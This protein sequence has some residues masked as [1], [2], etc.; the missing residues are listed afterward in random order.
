L[1]DRDPV[2][3]KKG[4]KESFTKCWPVEYNLQSECY[5]YK[6]HSEELVNQYKSNDSIHFFSQDEK[7]KTLEYEIARVNY[8]NGTIL[9]DS[10]S[11]KDELSLMMQTKTFSEAKNKCKSDNLN[12]IYSENINWEDNDKLVGLISARYLKSLQK[13]ENALELANL[14]QELSNDEKIKIVV[15]DYI[16]TAI[17]WLLN[18]K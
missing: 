12:K 5:D 13:G 1:T 14:L 18:I 4:T 10:I 3:R 11:N 8:N 2:R 15:P 9:V 17:K 6:N 7:G 16:K